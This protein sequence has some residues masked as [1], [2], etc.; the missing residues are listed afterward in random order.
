MIIKVDDVAFFSSILRIIKSVCFDLVFF[1]CILIFEQV[2]ALVANDTFR[3]V[4]AIVNL[5]KDWIDTKNSIF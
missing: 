2:D 5:I 3:E 1:F 4:A